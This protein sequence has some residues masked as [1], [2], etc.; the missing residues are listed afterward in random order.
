GSSRRATN[1]GHDDNC[2]QRCHRAKICADTEACRTR[3][4]LA[5]ASQN[6]L[7][8]SKKDEHPAGFVGWML[9]LN[10]DAGNVSDKQIVARDSDV[11]VARKRSWVRLLPV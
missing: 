4:V 8:E 3:V 9:V 11:S 1:G 6:D 5:F 7:A 2:H 10:G